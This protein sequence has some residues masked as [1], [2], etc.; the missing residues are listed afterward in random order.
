[1]EE[2]KDDSE[3]PAWLAVKEEVSWL[4]QEQPMCEVFRMHPSSSD[5]LPL[6]KQNW[7]NIEE[8]VMEGL[9]ERAQRQ[10]RGRRSFLK[11]QKRAML[12]LFLVVNMTISE[13]NTPKWKEELCYLY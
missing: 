6:Q 13:T 11:L 10:T 8:E 1:M 4:S 12:Q 5:P 9:C 7:L 3:T 2:R